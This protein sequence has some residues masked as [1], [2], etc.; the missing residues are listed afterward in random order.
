MRPGENFWAVSSSLFPTYCKIFQL[1]AWATWM[2]PL[3]S[4]SELHLRGPLTPSVEAIYGNHHVECTQKSLS[5]FLEGPKT[6][7]TGLRESQRALSNT[8]LISRGLWEELVSL[9][10]VAV[11]TKCDFS[12]INI[13]SLSF[14]LGLRCVRR[15]T[16]V[17]APFQLQKTTAGSWMCWVA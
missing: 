16:S 14:D 13:I 1:G 2:L 10:Q 5:W 3:V 6:V 12:C 11:R 8:Q 7:M 9:L 15:E 17:W 4:L